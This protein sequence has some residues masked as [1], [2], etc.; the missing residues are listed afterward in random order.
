M[1]LQAVVVDPG[2]P[3]YRQWARCH[4]RRTEA[5]CRMSATVDWTR[6]LGTWFQ[7]WA[8]SW[9]VRQSFLSSLCD[10]AVNF[11]RMCRKINRTV[12]CCIVYCSELE[13]QCWLRFLYVFC[14]IS[15][16]TVT[17]MYILVVDVYVKS[18]FFWR[19]LCL[20]RRLVAE[21]M[22]FSGCPHVCPWSVHHLHESLLAWYL[23]NH[24]REFH[25]IYSRGQRWTD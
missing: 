2:V 16:L 4:S 25:Q 3:P 23:T 20:R 22:Q 13:S 11:S 9:L 19:F 24:L 14:C 21:G 5:A 7:G 8:E 18:W 15:F 10:T 12:L 17:T 6:Q 1:R